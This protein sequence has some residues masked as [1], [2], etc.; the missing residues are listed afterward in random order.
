MSDAS[1]EKRE[2]R[3]LRIVTYPAPLL[4]NR[5]A[6]VEEI[7][8]GLRDTAARMADTM[9]DHHGVGLAAPQVG[10]GK[11]VIVFSPTGDPEDMRV[12][13]NPVIV[14]RRGAMEGE[15]GCLSFPEVYGMVRRSAYVKVRRLRPGRQ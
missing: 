8:S 5:A 14:E 10:I 1:A 2:S 12:L 9:Y 15:E 4:R 13:I 11:R 6:D 7:N 3:L